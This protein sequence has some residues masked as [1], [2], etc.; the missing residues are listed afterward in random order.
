VTE[1]RDHSA[2][3]A[4]RIVAAA[5]RAARAITPSLEAAA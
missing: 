3:A 1:I 5:A 2:A 4:A